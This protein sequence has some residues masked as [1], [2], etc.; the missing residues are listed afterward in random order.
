MLMCNTLKSFVFGF[1]AIVVITL[2]FYTAEFAFSASNLELQNFNS[3]FIIET[4]ENSPLIIGKQLIF[5]Y[6]EGVLVNTVTQ[7]TDYL[8][9]PYPS[10][11]KEYPKYYHITADKNIININYDKKN[12]CVK[13]KNQNLKVPLILDSSNMN[14]KIEDEKLFNAL[15]FNNN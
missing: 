14:G 1:I 4:A 10:F 12:N 15:F 3:V 7:L 2:I 11:D 13:Y 5:G 6:K 9:Y 8:V